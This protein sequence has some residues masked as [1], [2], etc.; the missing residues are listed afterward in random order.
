MKL[1]KTI[2]LPS[3]LVFLMRNAAQEQTGKNGGWNGSNVLCEWDDNSIG[4]GGTV[5]YNKLIKNSDGT[6]KIIRANNGSKCSV[7]DFCERFIGKTLKSLERNRTKSVGQAQMGGSVS[8]HGFSY[9][10]EVG[11][12]T[13]DG[14]Y[15]V[16]IWNYQHYDNTPVSELSHSQFEKDGGISGIE[17]TLYEV[18]RDEFVQRHG[19]GKSYNGWYNISHTFKNL[20]FKIS[21]T[22]IVS[23]SRERYQYRDA[24]ITYH[25]EDG[26]NVDIQTKTKY[27][28][29]SVDGDN[30]QHYT[31]MTEV[32]DDDGDNFHSISTGEEN[33][34]FELY[35]YNTIRKSQTDKLITLKNNYGLTNIN[36]THYNKLAYP[37]IDVVSSDLTFITQIEVFPGMSEERWDP[38][39]NN[40]KGILI[41]DSESASP[42]ARMK[43]QFKN[44]AFEIEV[45]KKYKSLLESNELLSD[46]SGVV[47]KKQ[48]DREIENFVNILKDNTH[49][50]NHITL[51]N[52]EKLFGSEFDLS[53]IIPQNNTEYQH[54]LDITFDKDYLIEW[55]KDKMDDEHYTELITRITMKHSFKKIVWV[56]G[57]L[58]SD[59]QNKLQEHL[60]NGRINMTGIE[61]V[62]LIDKTHLYEANGFH[63]VISVF[64]EK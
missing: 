54:K 21:P 32:I 17:V 51:Q 60:T 20:R 23:F 59:L 50:N 56:H 4:Y 24:K 53:K 14:K 16:S 48:E 31:Q 62:L 12:A 7:E 1:I 41:L 58:N 33:F 64:E 47:A 39:F 55:Q 10:E 43:T 46:T 49:S 22:D 6:Y 2:N 34:N 3:T 25:F 29:P 26:D 9:N 36:P 63:K 42:F 30:I 28:F 57:G 13:P 11:F 61:S 19:L 37:T 15:I 45:R 52:T 40:G 8:T 35:H 5:V 38:S 27:Y 44:T 18:T